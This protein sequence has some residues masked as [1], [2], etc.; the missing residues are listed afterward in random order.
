[1]VPQPSLDRECQLF[2]Q[3]LIALRPSGYVLRKYQEA[4]QQGHP[5]IGRPLQLFDDIL[6]RLALKHAY[7]LRLADTYSCLFYKDALL[8]RKLVLLLAILEC[9]PGAFDRLDRPE[10]R[11]RPALCGLLILKGLAFGAMVVLS[12][13]MLAPIHGACECFRH[14][15]DR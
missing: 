5:S 4:H 14:R 2:S 12:V 9:S 8:R 10:V 6:M 3:Y 15:W 1:M 7:I 13:A 11:S